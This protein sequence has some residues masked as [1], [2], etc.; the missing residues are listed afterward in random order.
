MTGCLCDGGG[1]RVGVQKPGKAM[2]DRRRERGHVPLLSSPHN[3]RVRY[4]SL[5]RHGSLPSM[6]QVSGILLSVSNFRGSL[7]PVL[8][9]SSSNA[10]QTQIFDNVDQTRGYDVGERDFTTPVGTQ[11]LNLVD[12]NGLISTDG[13]FMEAG[14]L[15]RAV[16]V[17]L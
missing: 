10:C 4:T 3:R 15:S 5:R 16:P 13:R 8:R 14:R 9:E 6:L 17:G 11:C 12:T 1:G 7:I 2:I